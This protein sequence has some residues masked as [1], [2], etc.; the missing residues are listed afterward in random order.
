MFTWAQSALDARLQPIGSS[1]GE[2]LPILQCLPCTPT[3]AARKHV[4]A[5]QNVESTASK[6]IQGCCC[7]QEVMPAARASCSPHAHECMGCAQ[8]PYACHSSQLTGLAIAGT[9]LGVADVR[10]LGIV[11]TRQR[12]GAAASMEPRRRESARATSP[13]RLA[14]Q[15][16]QFFERLH[17]FTRHGW[18][19]SSIS[20]VHIFMEANAHAHLHVMQNTRTAITVSTAVVTGHRCMN[21]F[22]SSC[23]SNWPRHTVNRSCPATAAALPPEDTL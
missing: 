13:E 23:S 19:H 18:Y 11:S 2:F 16:H 15:Q 14:Q 7:D 6:R 12:T 22:A 4:R 3:T 21:C 17:C 10:Y 9:P 5:P 8:R 1:G 20:L